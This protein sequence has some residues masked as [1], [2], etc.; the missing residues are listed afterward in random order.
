MRACVRACVP[1]SNCKAGSCLLAVNHPLAACCLCALQHTSWCVDAYAWSEG[2]AAVCVKQQRT[3]LPAAHLLHQADLVASLLQHAD[4][5]CT[6]QARSM[7]HL[8]AHGAEYSGSDVG[9][10][11]KPSSALLL[12]LP[13]RAT[14]CCGSGALTSRLERSCV[15]A[16]GYDACFSFRSWQVLCKF[17]GVTSNTTCMASLRAQQRSE[18]RRSMPRMRAQRCAQSPPPSPPPPPRGSSDSTLPQRNCSSALRITRLA[19]IV[20]CMQ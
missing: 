8:C 2:H 12:H 10:R 7:H 5:V 14:L 9:I 18:H 11:H 4:N 3:R 13:Q 6:K 15:S 16:V 17:V 19:K 20:N 1:Y